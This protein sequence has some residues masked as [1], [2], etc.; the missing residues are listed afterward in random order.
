MSN[1]NDRHYKVTLGWFGY[2]DDKPYL[3]R[4]LI[5]DIVIHIKSFNEY[6]V[7]LIDSS[8]AATTL[9]RVHIPDDHFGDVDDLS[10]DEMIQ[11]KGSI[12]MDIVKTKTIAML[13]RCNVKYAHMLYEIHKA[14]NDLEQSERQQNKTIH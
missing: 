3:K 1:G 4:K 11:V 13:G 6:F 10:E 8:F 12:G 5:Y 9:I 2:T 14:V 7:Y